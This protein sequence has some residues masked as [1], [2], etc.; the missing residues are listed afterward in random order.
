M[1]LGAKRR[2]INT[3]PFLSFNEVNEA[4]RTQPRLRLLA[5]NMF[6][7]SPSKRICFVV[8]VVVCLSVCLSFSDFAQKLPNA[9]A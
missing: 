1:Y 8:F 6:S 9:F 7:L 5:L 3:L 2:Y 4:D